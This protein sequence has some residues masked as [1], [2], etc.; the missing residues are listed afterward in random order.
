[1]GVARALRPTDA[2]GTAGTA[3]HR[4]RFAADVRAEVV[5][6]KRARRLI[7]YD[8]LLTL[9][10]DALTDPDTGPAAVERV[11]CPGR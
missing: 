10:R 5:R 7:D 6:R 11:R 3:A 9:R 2:A 8:D 4:Y 1:M